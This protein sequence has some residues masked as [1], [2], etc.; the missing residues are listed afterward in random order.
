MPASHLADRVVNYLG[1]RV[2]VVRSR[3]VRT[4]LAWAGDLGGARLLDVAGGD[5]YWAS[6]AAR[7]GAAATCLD[8]DRPKL[9]RGRRLEP[10]PGLVEGDALGLPFPDQSFDVVL[11]VCAIEHFDDGPA[12]TAE[13]AR[14]LRPGGRLVM[15]ADSLGRASEWPSLM[16]AH[17]RRYHVQATYT[18]ASLTSALGEQGFD[19]EKHSYLFRSRLAEHLYLALSA[20]GGRMGWNLAAPLAP[21]VAASDRVTPNDQGSVVLIAARKA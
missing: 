13:M 7:R 10:R 21:V 2:H 19:V 15:S 11:S 17:R 12:S 8:L 4:L 16:E 9:D 3:E 1:H 5:G 20:R 18:H 14:V 6:V